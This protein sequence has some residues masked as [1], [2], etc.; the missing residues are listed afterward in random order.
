MGSS[1][2]QGHF[3]SA[4][5]AP[6]AG[7]E[8]PF[9]LL[10]RSDGTWTDQTWGLAEQQKPKYNGE[11]RY[12]ARSGIVKILSPGRRASD[13]SAPVQL[14]FSWA[15]ARDGTE[16]LVHKTAGGKAWVLRRARSG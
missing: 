15:L 11:Y 2:C 1:A 12:D 16:V 5:P 10:I 6:A 7:F 9:K 3:P 4:I 8:P 14:E 13:E